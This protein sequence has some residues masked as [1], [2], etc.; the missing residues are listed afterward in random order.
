MKNFC[1]ETLMHILQALTFKQE[2]INLQFRSEII[3]KSSVTVSLKLTRKT[4][5]LTSYTYTGDRK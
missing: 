4:K 3:E 1:L 5:V 2:M